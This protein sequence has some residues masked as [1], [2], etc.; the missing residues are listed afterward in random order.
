[1]IKRANIIE[2]ILLIAAGVALV[3][4]GT[5]S[6]VIGFS[7]VTAVLALQLLRRERQPAPASSG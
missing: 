6:D 7:A 1:M 5:V 4:P 2:R 3:L